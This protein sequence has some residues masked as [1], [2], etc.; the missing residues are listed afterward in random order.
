[1][2]TTGHSHSAPGAPPRPHDP[3]PEG[4]TAISRAVEGASR[5]IP[6]EETN[7]KFPIPEGSQQR[8]AAPARL[9]SQKPA[10]LIDCRYA[11]GFGGCTDGNPEDC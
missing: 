10:P 11:A 4:I 9:T 8:V 2:N 7:E 3:D 5:P 1:M 6:P